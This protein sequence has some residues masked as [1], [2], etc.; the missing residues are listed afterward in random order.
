[1]MKSIHPA[2]P[3]ELKLDRCIDMLLFTLGNSKQSFHQ[4]CF[5]KYIKQNI[6]LSSCSL[7]RF[8]LCKYSFV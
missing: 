4:N 2:L 3:L 6:D 7:P 8:K 1:M 5:F